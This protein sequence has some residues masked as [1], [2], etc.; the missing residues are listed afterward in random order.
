MWEITLDGAKVSSKV[1]EVSRLYN[2]FPSSLPAKVQVGDL[3]S[4]IKGTQG[5]RGGLRHWGAAKV[6]RRRA[7]WQQQVTLAGCSEA[8]LW[9]PLLAG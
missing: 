4:P 1:T 2:C 6:L 5:D 7:L 9:A 8:G 3:G